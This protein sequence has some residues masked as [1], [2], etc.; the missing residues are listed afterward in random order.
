MIYRDLYIQALLAMQAMDTSD[1]ES[2]FQV[3]GMRTPH[4]FLN[5][6]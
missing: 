1:P 2:Y 5:M 6:F 3:S 4:N